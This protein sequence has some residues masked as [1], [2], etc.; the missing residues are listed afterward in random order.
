M[1]RMK[2]GSLRSSTMNATSFVESR[3]RKSLSVSNTLVVELTSCGIQCT[4]YNFRLD[5][6]AQIHVI[7]QIPV[8]VVKEP[9][10]VL[11][12]NDS[13]QVVSSLNH[14]HMSVPSAAE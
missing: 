12:L 8:R 5:N 1:F 3:R 4:L 7:D 6:K 2:D 13:K 9:D 14:D 11:T 10:I